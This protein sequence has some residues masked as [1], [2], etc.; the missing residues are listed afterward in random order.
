MSEFLTKYL[1][2]GYVFDKKDA[3]SDQEKAYIAERENYAFT[4]GSLNMTYI[5][6]ETGLTTD[7]DGNEIKK[8][9]AQFQAE[10]QEIVN[11]YKEYSKKRYDK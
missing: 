3:D 10:L 8:T 6:P 2:D 11:K 1:N 5:D 4:D 9:Y 7:E